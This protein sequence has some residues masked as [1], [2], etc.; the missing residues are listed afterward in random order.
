MAAKQI[1]FYKGVE[2]LV[3]DQ[4]IKCSPRG[5]DHP[6]WL[7][8]KVDNTDIEAVKRIIDAGRAAMARDIR[9]LRDQEEK[10]LGER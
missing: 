3:W 6:W 2:I 7:M 10:L 5:G 9:E 4:S 8:R 1:L